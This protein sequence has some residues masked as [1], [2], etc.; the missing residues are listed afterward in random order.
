MTD[1]T[2]EEHSLFD[3][4][5]PE[6]YLEEWY[7][8]IAKPKTKQENIGKVSM[9]I[10]RLEDEW[11][12]LPA[13]TVKEV[14]E[15]RTVHRI[16]GHPSDNLLGTVNVRGKLQLCISLKKLLGLTEAQK[17]EEKEFGIYPRMIVMEWEGERWVAP[18]DEIAGVMLIDPEQK[19]EAPVTISKAETSYVKALHGWKNKKVAALDEELLFYTLR[20]EFPAEDDDK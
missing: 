4:P 10:F 12:M 19:E 2:T 5:H 13:N 16:P 17:E 9:I 15:D 14:V 6:G 11:M 20:K 7:E 8:E 1:K 3:H 18:V